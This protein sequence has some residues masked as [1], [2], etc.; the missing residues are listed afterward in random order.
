M[1]DVHF[2]DGERVI[3]EAVPHWTGCGGHV[4]LAVLTLGIWLPVLLVVMWMRRSTR[5]VLTNFRVLAEKGVISKSSKSSQLDKINDV[6]VSQS[7]LGRMMGF[8]DVVLETAAEAGASVL[9][10]IPDPIGFQ[11]AL[12]DQIA[13]FKNQAANPPPDHRGEK[14]CP[15]CAEW[16]KQEARICRY[17]RH[18]LASCGERPAGTLTCSVAE[19]LTRA[20]SPRCSSSSRD[21]EPMP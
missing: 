18:P 16:V 2:R 4:F 5:Y 3:R 7:L 6:M 9:A 20:L 12:L 19:A 13:A 11:R 8:G 14:K 10:R 21:I 1:R 15:M 17:C